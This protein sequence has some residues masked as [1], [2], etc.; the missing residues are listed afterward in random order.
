MST[1]SNW[2]EIVVRERR[3]EL[4]EA[5]R[6]LDIES[7]YG[8]VVDDE[9]GPGEIEAARRLTNRYHREVVRAWHMYRI[10]HNLWDCRPGR[11]MELTLCED[12]SRLPVGQL[13]EVTSL[14]DLG[15]AIPALPVDEDD[16]LG[17]PTYGEIAEVAVGT[18]I[19][20]GWRIAVAGLAAAGLQALWDAP[21]WVSLHAIE[22][23]LPGIGWTS[24]GAGLLL[25]ACSAG[26]GI[27]ELRRWRR[28]Q[29]HARRID[30]FEVERG[31]V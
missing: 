18:V 8:L 5:I 11:R 24:L 31:D 17:E 28:D 4:V 19:Y 21:S 16:D 27:L 12:L 20:Y 29:D 23:T 10:A 26:A 9:V 14:E 30:A 7:L 22:I 2:R 6:D 25:G 3:E 13:A 15:I 1:K